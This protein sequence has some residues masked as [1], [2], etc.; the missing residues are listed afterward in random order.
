[1]KP[2]DEKTVCPK[3]GWK[4]ISTRYH[5][6]PEPLQACAIAGGGE[7]MHRKCE[8]CGYEWLEGPLEVS[9]ER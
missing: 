9:G 4:V 1:M 5:A 7:H 2:Y 8:R 6:K 3:C